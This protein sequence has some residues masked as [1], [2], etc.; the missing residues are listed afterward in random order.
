[1]ADQNV[2]QDPEGH[3]WVTF[4]DLMDDA[5]EGGK[6]FP[7]KRR[8]STLGSMGMSTS[9]SSNSSFE[10]ATSPKKSPL[11]FSQSL[12]FGKERDMEE[13]RRPERSTTLSSL[14]FVTKVLKFL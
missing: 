13:Q 10:S 3:K 9:V 2:A 12:G 4:H 6:L 1:M 11:D 5:M 14:H 7:M 8:K